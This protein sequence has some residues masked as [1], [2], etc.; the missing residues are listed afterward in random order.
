MIL[1]MGRSL[2]VEMESVYMTVHT[3]TL[4]FTHRSALLTHSHSR[5]DVGYMR[6]LLSRSAIQLP[7]A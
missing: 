5:K 3:A 2:I 7:G 1:G 4:G 6:S